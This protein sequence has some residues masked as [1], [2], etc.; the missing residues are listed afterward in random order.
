MPWAEF[1][2]ALVEFL[3]LPT[4][5]TPDVED[6]LTYLRHLVGT[7]SPKVSIEVPPKAV[8][9]E[10]WGNLLHWFGPLTQGSAFLENV[11]TTMQQPWFHGDLESSDAEKALADRK[12][13]HFLVRMS[14][15]KP[16]SFTISKMASKGVNHQRVAYK[17]ETRTFSIRIS[18]G[19]GKKKSVKTIKST[20][21]L[22]EFIRTKLSGELMLKMPCPGS[23]YAFLYG[24]AVQH[25][26][27][28]A[29]DGYVAVEESDSGEESSDY[30]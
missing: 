10:A 14:T 4:P 28:A 6:M 5:I 2:T 7:R 29:V 3:G 9:L 24:M 26:P 11:R 27:A 23:K 21:S 22:E 30:D 19:H 12:K 15:T 1:K 16:G 25:D 13:G 17:A 18:K 8:S 20:G